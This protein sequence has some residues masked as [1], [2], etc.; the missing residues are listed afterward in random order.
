MFILQIKKCLN[1]ILCVCVCVVV[2]PEMLFM[3]HLEARIN[4]E[5]GTKQV[6]SINNTPVWYSAGS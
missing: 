2:C 6:N 5:H 4:G 3:M 1:L